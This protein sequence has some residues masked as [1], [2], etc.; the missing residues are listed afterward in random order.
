MWIPDVDQVWKLASIK[1][2]FNNES[3]TLFIEDESNEVG[4]C[5]FLHSIFAFINLLKLILDLNN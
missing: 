3:K 5:L 4:S 2:D 1:K